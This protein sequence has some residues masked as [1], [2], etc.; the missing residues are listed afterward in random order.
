MN[1]SH[2]E[3]VTRLKNALYGCAVLDGVGEK[4]EFLSNISKEDVLNHANN[5]KVIHITD[6]TQMTLFGFEAM[7]LLD[8]FYSDT[9]NII[10]NYELVLDSF[11][12][13]YRTWYYTQDGSSLLDFVESSP[14]HLIEFA[15]MHQIRAPGTTCLRALQDL[16]NGF[17]VKNDSKGCGSVMRLLP[18]VKFIPTYGIDRAIGYAQITGNITH[19]H[20]ENDVAIERYMRYANLC[21]NGHPEDYSS[22]QYEKISNI[23]EGWTALECVN[24]AIWAVT[25]AK[26]FDDLLRLSLS[27]NGDSDSVG[28]VAGGLWGLQ[29]KEVP[30]KY[31]DKIYEKDCIDFIIKTIK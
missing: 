19:K 29:G 23:G 26:S 12:E 2:S 4:F 13:Q 22:L 30:Q 14:A 31:I 17:V 24:M 8:R 18:C 27:H 25:H 15:N 21:L 7:K 20:S 6:D 9:R 16:K 10:D 11:T 5:S 1:I 3:F 28:A